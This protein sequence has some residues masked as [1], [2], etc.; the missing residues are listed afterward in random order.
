MSA[1][2]LP[3]VA[4]IRVVVSAGGVATVT[5]DRPERRNA[6]TLAMWQGLAAL[7]PA[8]SAAPEVRA[9]VLTGAGAD[10]TAG[11]DISEFAAVRDDAAQALEYERWVDAGCEAIAGCDKPVIA[12]CRGYALGGGAHV[13]M[14]CD[15]RFAAP[16]AQFGIPAARL[17]IVYGVGATR[18]LMALVGL[19]EAKRILF[20]GERFDGRAA[21]A[22]GFVER[23][24]EDPLAEAVAFAE[25]LAANAPLTIAG[26]K[27]ILNGLALGGFDDAEA[28]RRID[29]AA[30]SADYREG[31]AAFAERR[32]PQFRG[33]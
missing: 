18:K 23:L 20:T 33:A 24:A 14:S 17:S 30:A 6:L 29:E 16:E 2:G 9:V 8:L 32:A 10:F 5:L 4:D 11:A 19:A 27:Y 26:A 22:S 21:L 1:A 15:F 3:E 12:A 13:A 28:A 7:F 25:G 31:R